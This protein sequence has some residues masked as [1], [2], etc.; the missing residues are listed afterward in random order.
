M[1]R[2]RT[3]SKAFLLAVA[4]AVAVVLAA[5]PAAAAPPTSTAIAF[6]Q[7][8]DANNTAVSLQ[9]ARTPGQQSQLFLF[10]TQRFCDA[11][12]DETV[13]RS[14]AAQPTISGSFNVTGSLTKASLATVVSGR[15]TEQ[16]LSS[17]TSPSGVPTFV[18]LGIVNV[19]LSAEWVATGPTFTVQPGIV[20]RAS[21]ATGTLAGPNT[22][23]VGQLGPSSSAELRRSML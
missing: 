23:A 10:V 9:S 8:S 2:F 22:L 6:W 13:F 1:R 17:C 21:T 19:S 20:A 5:A 7:L 18:D 16:R 12:T 3:R 15:Q 14:F 11:S 4:A